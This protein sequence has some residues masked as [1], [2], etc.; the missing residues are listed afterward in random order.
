M[1]DLL[2]ASQRAASVPIQS[3]YASAVELLLVDFQE[4]TDKKLGGQLFDRE[5]S[6][7]GGAGKSPV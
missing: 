3:A 5:T 2:C 7:V 4:G 1:C 6:C